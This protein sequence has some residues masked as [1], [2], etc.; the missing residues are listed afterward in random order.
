MALEGYDAVLAFGEV[1]AELYR[2]SGWG[3]RVF[4]W[5]EA[6]D[7]RLFHPLPEESREEELV[8]IGNWGDGE[9]ARE[10]DEFLICVWA[11][12][13]TECAIRRRRCSPSLPQ[14]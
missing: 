14:D 7:L 2:R 4:T 8:W 5:H 13:S 10:L 6:A 1:L 12:A 9:R 3:R 11:A